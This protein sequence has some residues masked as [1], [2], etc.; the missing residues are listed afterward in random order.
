MDPK[1]TFAG[2]IESNTAYILTAC[3]VLLWI[4]FWPAALVI[5]IGAAAALRQQWRSKTGIF[6]DDTK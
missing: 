6:S 5:T 1:Y 3:Y 4:L 2:T